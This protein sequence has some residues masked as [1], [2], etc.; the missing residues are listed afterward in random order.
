M[1]FAFQFYLPTL[2]LFTKKLGGENS[3][4]G[5]VSGVFT[6]T[7]LLMRVF[8]GGLLDKHGRKR[9]FILSFVVFA[10]SKISYMFA[11][12]IAVLILVRLFHGFSWGIISTASNTVA[13]DIIPKSRLSEGT[14]FLFVATTSSLLISPSL[15]LKIA[16]SLGFNWLFLISALI[17]FGAMFLAFPISYRKDESEVVKRKSRFDFFEIEASIPS[18]IILLLNFGYSTVITFLSLY[19]LQYGIKNSGVFFT[20]YGISMIVTRLLFGKLGDKKGFNYV[21][22]PGMLIILVGGLFLYL[23]NNITLLIISGA[24]YGAGFGVVV[25]TT[26]AMAVMNVGYNRR[27]AANATFFAGLDAGIGA[28]SVFWGFVANSFGLKAIYLFALIP[29]VL[30]FLIYLFFSSRYRK[31]EAK[32]CESSV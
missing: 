20:A 31:T 16:D 2:A 21:M 15:G 7:A 32:I 11:T 17:I 9:I 22:I 5:I 18:L 3:L 28:G 23:T 29:M 4:V 30:A 19:T 13:T 14:G 6:I 12:S 26:Q 25:P 8:S 1:F 27:G 10:L 24:L